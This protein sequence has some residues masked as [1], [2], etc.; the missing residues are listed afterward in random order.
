MNKDAVIGRGT[1]RITGA[2]NQ[3]LHLL[4]KSNLRLTLLSQQTVKCELAF[5]EN[6][7]LRSEMFGGCAACCAATA[8]PRRK[9]F[10]PN[11][12]R[13]RLRRHSR[14][15]GERSLS[16]KAKPFPHS[17]RQSRKSAQHE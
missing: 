2:E 4:P 12:L 11:A 17:K 7:I 15:S 8:L 3:N 16:G 9:C 6:L 10:S 13:L 1:A 14:K 5:I